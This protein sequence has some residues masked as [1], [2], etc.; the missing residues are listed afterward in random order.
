MRA[1]E[2]CRERLTG[3]GIDLNCYNTNAIAADIADLR[4]ALGIDTYNLLTI[5][6][7]TKIAQVLLRDYPEGIRSVVMDSPLPLE[8]RY[9]E[10]SVGNLLEAVEKLLSDCASDADCSRAFPE[11]KQRFFRYL[12]EKTARPL[13]LS[14]QNP[15]DGKTETFRLEGK[16]LIAV[17]TSASTGDVAGIPFEMNRLLNGD[18][19]LVKEQLAYRFGEPGEGAGMG[20]RLSVWCAVEYPFAAQEKI[21]EETTRYPELKGLSPAVFFG[22]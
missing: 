8:V 9:D 15:N 16:D 20:M 3:N 7:S 18:P 17:F 19:G 1:A 22:M 13:E 6:Y 11:L 5:S 21:S 14:V 12:R 10:E 4:K 2:A